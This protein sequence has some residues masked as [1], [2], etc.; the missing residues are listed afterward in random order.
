MANPIISG[1]TWKAIR[2]KINEILNK[3]VSVDLAVEDAEAARD[4]AALSA[5]SA[6]NAVT[7]LNLPVATGNPDTV[8]GV[9]A[10]G[11]SY[12]LRTVAQLR[13]LL[14]FT[15]AGTNLVTAADAAAQLAALGISGHGS[16][17]VTVTNVNTIEIGGTYLAVDTASGLPVVEWCVVT[18]YPG[19]TIGNSVQEAF[20]LLSNRRWWRRE[21][22]SVWQS[23]V[24]VQPSLGFTPVEQ[25]GGSFMSG[26]K[27]RIGWDVALDAFRLQVDSI[28]LGGIVTNRS[29]DAA[30]AN[31]KL[32]A[33]GSAPLYACR[34]W[35]NF[36]GVGGVS[37]RAGE[38]ISSIVRNSVGDYT[39][40]FATAMPDANYV[41][42]ANCSRGAGSSLARV[43]SA[44]IAQSPTVSA[45]R[46]ATLDMAGNLQDSEF[47][48]V[49]IFR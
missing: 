44:P 36:N 48:T 17:G 26:N 13:T 40:N 21:I 43:V 47:I 19:D 2:E 33:P 24:E 49:A 3:T 14:G 32:Y 15:T 11:N 39:I 5:E 1:D 4:A 10:A 30:V 34:A 9:N 23:W 29:A 45:V 22:N 38:N 12:I 27:A 46:I 37:P 16:T 35:A 28:P 8:L 41:V 18:H 31:C 42:V 25:S 6:N 20:S 7:S